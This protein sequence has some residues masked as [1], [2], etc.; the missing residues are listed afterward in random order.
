MMSTR[1]LPAALVTLLLLAAPAFA[2]DD[3]L[4]PALDRYVKLPAEK[5]DPAYVPTRCAGLYVGILRYGGKSLDPAQRGNIEKESSDLAL[6]AMEVRAK[7]KGGEPP[8][9]ADSVLGVVRALS[10]A[11]V[12]RMKANQAKSGQA[13]MSDDLMKSDIAFC[14]QVAGLLPSAK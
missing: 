6:A 1:A 10:D 14:K 7:Q 4:S 2:A 13:F 9:Y 8:D 11:Y 5:Q 3:P 12:N